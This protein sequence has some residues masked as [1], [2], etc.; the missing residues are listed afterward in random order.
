MKHEVAVFLSELQPRAGDVL[1]QMGTLK[2]G[3]V[4]KCSTYA[5]AIER[6]AEWTNATN[7]RAV[8]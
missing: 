3:R 2:I 8:A 5:E 1:M 6:A 7:P 4:E